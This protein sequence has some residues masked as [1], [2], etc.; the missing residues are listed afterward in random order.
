MINQPADQEYQPCA[1]EEATH[2]LFN[3]K[4]ERI[5]GVGEYP[6]GGFKLVSQSGGRFFVQSEN[7]CKTFGIIPVKEVTK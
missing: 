3:N 4:Y 5:E 7:F 6:D 2:V 1:L